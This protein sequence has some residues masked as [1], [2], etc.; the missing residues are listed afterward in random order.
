[1]KILYQLSFLF[2]YISINLNSFSNY[3]AEIDS[4]NQF[5]AKNKFEDAISGYK[6]IIDSGVESSA[7]YYNLGN[8]YFKTNN[9]PKAI[10]NYERALL[11]N[12]NDEDIK[13][14]LELANTFIIDK[15][16]SIPP[17]FLKLWLNN[18]S[19][20]MQSNNWAIISISGFIIFLIFSL[21]YLFTNKI[22]VKKLSFWFGIVIFIISISA[23]GFANRNKNLLTKNNTAIIMASS[24]TAKSTPDESGTDLFV[25]HEGTK[26]KVNDKI[27]NWVEIK[28]SDGNKGWI[29]SQQLEQIVNYNNKKIF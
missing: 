25:V 3:Y 29:L 4:A 27:G 2:I 6:S 1:M 12:P 18:F 10:V 28:L 21:I 20:L 24:V 17:F 22:V 8:A 19:M 15:I 23:F 14:N 9:I 13:Y 16:E 11:L 26:V 5:Y 7:I